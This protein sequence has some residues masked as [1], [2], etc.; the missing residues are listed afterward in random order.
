[1]DQERALL[2]EGNPVQYIYDKLL[3]E[4]GGPL[5]WKSQSSEPCDKRQL[6]SQNAKKKCQGN[7]K[8]ENDDDLSNILHQ[9]KSI[10]VVEK[11]VNKKNC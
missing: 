7:D 4:S 2:A 9:L 8:G 5:K 3:D 10:N 1:M 11:I 6:Y